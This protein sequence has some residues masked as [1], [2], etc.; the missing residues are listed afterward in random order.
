LR[1][2]GGFTSREHVISEAL[3]NNA[4][5][6]DGERTL[7]P[8]V[9]CDRCNHGSLSAADSA[10]VELP[11]IQLLRAERGLP[12]K[13]LKPVEAKFGNATVWFSG[14]G[15]MNVLTNSRKTTRQMPA[16]PGGRMPPGAKGSIELSSGGPMT[17]R[18][19]RR[20]V[21]SGWKSAFEYLYLDHGPDVAFDSD[22]DDA[23]AAVIDDDAT[24]G[25]AVVPKHCDVRET[26]SVT[27]SF[28]MIDGRVAMPICLDVFGVTFYTDLLRRDLT[29]EQVRPLWEAN[30]WV[31][32]E[33]A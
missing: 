31:F 14:P 1:D 25:W 5:L 4:A 7:A 10:L 21:R 30:V 22:L 12:T 19:L 33:P 23:R 3:G 15:E 24:D 13:A 9:V 29:S 26:V 2:D 11:M 27:Y 16:R 6:G 20:A 32:N 17:S 8:G 28:C 18:R